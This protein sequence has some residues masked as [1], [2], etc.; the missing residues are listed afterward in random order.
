MTFYSVA[1][2]FFLQPNFYMKEWKMNEKT[3]SI[4]TSTIF[5]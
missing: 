2:I 3:D 5:A 4:K 1:G